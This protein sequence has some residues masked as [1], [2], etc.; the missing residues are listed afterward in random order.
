MQVTNSRYGG[1]RRGAIAIALML[2]LGVGWLLLPRGGR[3]SQNGAVDDAA[4]R[5]GLVSPSSPID[6]VIFM[7]KENRTFDHYFGRYPGADGASEAGTLRC[8]NG[9][10]R[11]GDTIPLK[12]APDVQPHDIT[13]GFA[14]GLYAINGGEMNGFN[15]IGGGQDLSGYVQHSR[16]SLPAYW[17]YAD[18]FVLAD[19]FFTS[20][21]GPTFPEHLFTVAAQSFDIVDNPSS[22]DAGNCDR[23]IKVPKFTTDLTEQDIS[24]IIDL[25]DGITEEIPEQL[26]RIQ[27]YWEQTISCFDIEVLPDQLERAGV[28]WRYYANPDQFMNGLQAVKHVRFGPMWDKVVPPEEFL[29]NVKSGDLPEVSWLVPPES[30]S[31]HPD[32]GGG[33]GVCG[34]ENW[35]VQQVNALMRSPAWTS[36]ALVIVWDDFG[37]FPDHVPPPHLDYMGLGPRTPALVI[38][39]YTV[40]GDN[41]DGGAIDSTTYEFSSVLGFIERLHGLEPMTERD[42]SA[43]PLTGA[44]D[45]TQAPRTEPLILSRRDCPN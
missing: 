37:G 11:A 9:G 5:R 43:D 34:G 35:T 8:T 7:I 27:A 33:V 14:S 36:T 40:R 20:M 6:H 30:F 19:R 1:P 24:R 10:C 31:E 42:A 26:E 32:N 28:S 15:I 23:K 13:H 12:P 39:P 45:F 4:Q 25:E 29:R 21:Y 38:S 18:R 16:K 3:S 22:E 2:V 17:A 44:F 41:P